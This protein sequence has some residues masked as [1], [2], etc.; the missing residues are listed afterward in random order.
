M[1]ILFC[2]RAVE[3]ALPTHVCYLGFSTG[4]VSMVSS[5]MQCII[6]Q[7]CIL[8]MYEELQDRT[9]R[10]FLGVLAV[11]FGSLVVVFAGFA[12]IG[13]LVFGPKVEGD[14][15]KSLPK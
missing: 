13:Y 1:G 12:C 2:H 14:V 15:L 10:K 7:M 6:V 8:P 5:L 4:S 9:P 11:A 3:H